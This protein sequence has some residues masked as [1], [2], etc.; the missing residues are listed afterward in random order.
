MLAV[1]GWMLAAQPY[2]GLWHDGI[3]YFGQV[4]RHSEVPALSE[5]MFFASGSQDRYSVYAHVVAP[6]YSALG[7]YATHVVGVLLSWTL[8]AGALLTLLKPLE[9]RWQPAALWGLLAYGVVSPIYG[10]GWVFGYGEPFLTA[11]TVAEPLLL[12]SLVAL[13]SGRLARVAGLQGAATLFHPLMA[14]PVVLVTGCYLAQKDRRWWWALCIVPLAMLAGAAGLPPWDGLLKRYDPYWW[15]LIGTVNAQVLLQN[16]S[17]LD[18]LTVGLDLA[19][20]LVVAKLRPSAGLTRLLHAVVITNLA[21]FAVAVVL[22]DGLQLVLVTQLQLWRAH[23]IAHLLAVATLPWL[24][25]QLWRLGGLWPTSACALALAMLNI[26]VGG[27]HG[28]A[29]T[30]LLLFTS[31]LAWRVRKVSASTRWLICGCI[32]LCIAAVSWARLRDVLALQAWQNPAAGANAS[33][34]LVLS[35]PTVAMSCFAA[36]WLLVQ[37]GRTALGFA[38]LSSAALFTVAAAAWD[39]RPDL[40]RAVESPSGASHPFAGHLPPRATVYWP[41][42]LL[43]VWGLLE[44]T[45]HFAPQQGSGMLFN[46]NTAMAF[47]ARRDQHRNINEDAANCRSDAMRLRDRELL[48][49]CDAPSVQQRLA[50]LCSAWDPPDFLVLP[51]HHART[52]LATW[53]PPTHRDPPLAYSLHSCRQFVALQPQR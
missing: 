34:M 10:G 3:L 21:L 48:A 25:M 11:R 53:Q 49:S 16:W 32:L 29:T 41:G 39:Q 14:L 19:V 12:W 33:A 24:V 51:Q 45:S 43:P 8:M 15:S 18:W 46:R 47:G 13:L 27:Q 35:F 37:R 22:A 7:K 38:A 4:L 5:D 23:W 28:P 36:L 1:L 44:R 9:Q 31:L 20:L 2:R 52:P 6:L 40:A 26:H 17:L 50:A 42:Q 30:A